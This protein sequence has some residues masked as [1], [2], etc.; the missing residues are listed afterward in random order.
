MPT[1]CRW[2]ICGVFAVVPTI[3][4]ERAGLI[5]IAKRLDA[6]VLRWGKL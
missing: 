6:Q 2:P 4:D 3:F 1:A 5:E